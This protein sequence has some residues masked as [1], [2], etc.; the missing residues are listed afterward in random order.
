MRL[1]ETQKESDGLFTLTQDMQESS[2]SILKML[3]AVQVIKQ[4]LTDPVNQQ[5]HLI[6]HSKR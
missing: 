2:E 5:L 6:K 1:L 3:D 4:L